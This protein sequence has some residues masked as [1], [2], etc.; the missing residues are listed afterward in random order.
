LFVIVLS[1][2]EFFVLL[3]NLPVLLL[4]VLFLFFYLLLHFYAVA[5][6]SHLVILH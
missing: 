1:T 3:L 2:L 6:L 5:L 4:D